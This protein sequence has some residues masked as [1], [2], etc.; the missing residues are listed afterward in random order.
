LCSHTIHD[1][2]AEKRSDVAMPPVMRPIIR[3]L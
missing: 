1:S 2:N 3:M